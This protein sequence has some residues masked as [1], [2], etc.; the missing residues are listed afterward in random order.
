V[1]LVRGAY[2]EKKP[3][4]PS[5][6]PVNPINST[7]QATD[8]PHDESL[9][10]L[11]EHGPHQH[12]RRHHNEA[13]YLTQRSCSRIS[14]FPGD[15]RVWFMQLYGMSDNLTYNLANAGYNTACTC[16]TAL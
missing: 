10:L 13:V 12:L 15:P 8:D 11:P 2:M 7:K 3:A 1:K 5:N 14:S 9:A 16:P 6:G 4:W